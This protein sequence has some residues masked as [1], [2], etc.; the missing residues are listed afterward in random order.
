[1]TSFIRPTDSAASAALRVWVVTTGEPLPTDAGG[2][3]LLR[4]G[5]VCGMMA[6]R[7]WDVTWWTSNFDHTSKIVRQ[8]DSLLAK[9]K[10]AHNYQIRLLA[11]RGY[12]RNV[13]WARLSDHREIAAGFTRYAAFEPLP[14]VILCSYP[15][16]EL[17]DAATRYGR[18]HGVPV[19]LDIR[20]L[21]PDIF[22]E[23]APR[24]LQWLARWLLLPYQRLGQRALQRA[25]AL[26]AITDPIL[27]WACKS[28]GRQSQPLDQAFPLA[29]PR[30]STM[31]SLG[32]QALQEAELSWQQRG[33]SRQRFVVCFFG[34]M[35]RQFDFETVLQA[36]KLME[37][38]CPQALFVLCGQ[39]Q[40]LAQ[41]Q[42]EAAKRPN[43]VVPGW[44]G[45]ADLQSLMHLSAAGLAP[46]INEYSFT[47]SVPNKIIEYLSGGLPVLSCLQG[48]TQQLL[49]THDCGLT[50]QENQPQSLCDSVLKLFNDADL[51]E[52]LARQGKA[53]YERQ[54]TAEQVYSKLLAYLARIASAKM[55]EAGRV[56]T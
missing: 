1:M 14:D 55:A 3:R 16:I 49:Q 42:L 11:S 36:A 41:L 40:M 2:V 4:H 56:S 54:F 52:R 43:L 27:G 24:G 20:D 30:P 21:W 25:H 39:G 28:A 38:Q 17:A 33:V 47:L 5:I 53:L 34:A 32:A 29:C 51:R 22:I 18:A 8:P 12:V 23:L 13:S 26:I 37:K 48:H 35:G 6:E 9:L 15:T 19:V 31:G 10:V 50:Y 44:L 7:G 45:Q 46:Y